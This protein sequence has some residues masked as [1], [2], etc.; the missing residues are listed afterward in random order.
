MATVEQ[1]ADLP[2]LISKMT[3]VPSTGD[4]PKPKSITGGCLCGGVKYRVDF[5]DGHDFRS[6]ARL[7]F[8]IAL[9]CPQLT[10]TG[11]KVRELPVH[12][13][14]QTNGRLLFRVPENHP[15]VRLPDHVVQG[16]AQALQRLRRR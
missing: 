2:D 8:Q 14:P 3:N 16:Y 5:P 12:A 4:F 6:Q 11:R 7:P 1:T 10:A 13:V 9:P 15:R